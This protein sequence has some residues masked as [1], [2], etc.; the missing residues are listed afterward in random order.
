MRCSFYCPIKQNLRTR[1]SPFSTS[2]LGDSGTN[3]EA[4][5]GMKNILESDKLLSYHHQ[6]SFERVGVIKWRNDEEEREHLP[7][8]PGVQVGGGG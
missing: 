8:L 5:D 6:D 2:V 1:W 3:S 4:E 7:T